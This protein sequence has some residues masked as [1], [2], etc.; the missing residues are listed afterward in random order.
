MLYNE[1]DEGLYDGENLDP[2]AHF[3]III[4]IP[5]PSCI[6]KFKP[7][8]MDVRSTSLNRY[9]IVWIRLAHLD[10]QF[11]SHTLTRSSSPRYSY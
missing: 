9:L 3:E 4:L 5:R 8:N 10:F 11:P 1:E 2:I 7:Y 6:L